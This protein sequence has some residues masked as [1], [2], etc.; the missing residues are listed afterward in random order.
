MP[1]RA[2]LTDPHFVEALGSNPILDF[3][4]HVFSPSPAMVQKELVNGHRM[5]RKFEEGEYNAE[6]YDIVPGMWDR[7]HCSVCSSRIVEGNRYWENSE[8]HVLCPDCYERFREM[9]QDPC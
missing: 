8:A 6:K 3:C 1:K 5:W 9:I 4:H 2:N 7:E